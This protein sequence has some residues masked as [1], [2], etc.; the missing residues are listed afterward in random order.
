MAVVMAELTRQVEVQCSERAHALALAWNLYSAAMDTCLGQHGSPAKPLHYT[1]GLSGVMPQP[2]RL[3]YT[4]TA[5]V[6]QI[7]HHLRHVALLPA[8]LS[9]LT[10]GSPA[11]VLLMSVAGRTMWPTSCQAP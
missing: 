9:N 1:G 6:L 3:M 8:V 7:A 5:S 4:S 10:A 11:V 2:S